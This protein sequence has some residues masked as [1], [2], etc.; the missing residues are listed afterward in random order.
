MATYPDVPVVPPNSPTIKRH[1]KEPWWRRAFKR[2][3]R[4][5]FHQVTSDVASFFRSSYTDINL[6]GF[7]SSLQK[8]AIWASVDLIG[9]LGSELP[10]D[11]FRRRTAPIGQSHIQPEE[12]DVPFWL[13]DPSG[14]GYG[15]EDWRYQ[16]FMSVL[17]R[18]N[19]FGEILEFAP[20]RQNPFPT[21][22]LLFHPDR[23]SLSVENGAVQ[24]MPF[25]RPDID[26]RRFWHNRINPIPGTIL[27]LSPVRMHASTI[28]LAIAATN[29]GRQ[30]FMDGAHPGG[31]LINQEVDMNEKQSQAAKEKFMSAL[32][33][34]REPAVLGKGWQYQRVQISPEESQFL[35]TQGYTSA[36]CARIFGPGM[37]E[38]LG[39][40]TGGAQTYANV[41]S[42][43]IH[44]LVYSLNKWFTRVERV[45]TSMLP[46]GQFAKLNRGALLQNTTLD[47]LRAW[48]IALRNRIMVV[49]EV[50]DKEDLSW[51]EWGDLPSPIPGAPADPVLEG[52]GSGG[53]SNG[54]NGQTET[55]SALVGA[56]KQMASEYNDWKL[57][58]RPVGK[59]NVQ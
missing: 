12:L 7:T 13:Q 29:F 33:G 26:Q 47:R 15:S 40:E 25:D 44:L 28:G 16:Y 27:G 46:R 19:A 52:E 39:Y 49:N 2:E 18:G 54:N 38:I 58:G 34:R 17:L 57:N 48:E 5:N 30:W 21:Q 24:W 31:L 37:A 32:R 1:R 9:S 53:N 42:R 20:G 56:V 6:S 36:E 45:Y 59:G 11:V 14:E 4:S 50:R 55:D 3:E 10:I 23:V 35:E 8:V 43:S 51:V 22:I 41:E